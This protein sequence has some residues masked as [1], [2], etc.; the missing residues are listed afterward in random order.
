VLVVLFAWMLARLLRVRP[1]ARTVPLV[2]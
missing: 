2:R 1:P